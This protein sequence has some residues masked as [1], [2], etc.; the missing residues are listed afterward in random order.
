A[1]TKSRCQIVRFGPV[2]E[3]RI[4][5]ALKKS[6]I[7]GKKALYF[8][9]LADGSIG[10]ALQMAALEQEG[11][12]L[13]EVKTAIVKSLA[14]MRYEQSLEIAAKL[15]AFAKEIGEVWVKQQEKTSKTDINRRA[16]GFVLEAVSCVFRDAMTMGIADEKKI[17]NI[18]Q[19]GE[20]RRIAAEKGGEGCAMAVENAYD[21]ERRMEANVNEKLIFERLLL[22]LASSDTM[23]V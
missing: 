6:G 3:E 16:I 5:E 2:D 19:L 1:T 10:E 22:K 14:D 20:I 15:L 8:T 9:R 7:E 21:A 18:D 13:F 11:A 4:L 12:K 17:A 23:K